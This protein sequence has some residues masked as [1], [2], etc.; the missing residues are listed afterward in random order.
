MKCFSI[1]SF[2]LFKLC[3]YDV[4][5]TYI[6]CAF[7]RNAS[8]GSVRLGGK[9][10]IS[11]CC[12]KYVIGRC[13]VI[14]TIHHQLTASLD[15]TFHIDKLISKIFRLLFVL[16]PNSICFDY[17]FRMEKLKRAASKRRSYHSC[18]GNAMHRLIQL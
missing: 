17:D 4:R 18:H 7:Q 9:C 16:T 11:L 15:T 1:E 14:T 10:G 5:C 13:D 8:T 3:M 6:S 2:P 12:E